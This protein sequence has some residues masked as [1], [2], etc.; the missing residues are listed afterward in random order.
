[1]T[2]VNPPAHPIIAEPLAPGRQSCPH[3]TA[4]APQR[5]VRD[6]QHAKWGEVRVY[7][8]AKCSREVEY[9]VRLP[10]HVV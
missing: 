9:L 2:F 5:F 1:M 7:L 4:P 10:P 3:C 8:C 6:Y